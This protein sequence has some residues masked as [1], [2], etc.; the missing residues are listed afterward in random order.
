MFGVKKNPMSLPKSIYNGVGK[1]LFI[2]LMCFSSF[3]LCF[4][5][6]LAWLIPYVGFSAI[7]SWLPFIFGGIFLLLILAISW[8]CLGLCY[9]VYTGKNFIGLK[10]IH[11]LTVKLM[12]PLMELLG[13]ALGVSREKIRLSFIKVNNEIVLSK[14]NIINNKI[15]AK[16]I[17]LLLPHCIQEANCPHRLTLKSDNCKKCG[18][19][20][21]GA[22]L[23]LS[24]DYGFSVAVATGG[25]IARKIVVDRKPKLI[26]AVAC[27]RDLTSGIQD[28]YPLPVY[29]ILNERP[30]GPCFNT[31]VNL[32]F[33][34]NALKIFV[35][36]E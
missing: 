27:E 36:K 33:L 1:S 32:D 14:F 20:P 16:K 22:I 3:V 35:S 7:H 9:Y 10:K 28:T 24:E 12:F 13:R 29:G 11:G 31:Q 19:C 6:A 18:N 4:T 23:N 30:F 34:Q 15:S 5:I 21:L 17:L 2:G 8:L 25:T 26:L